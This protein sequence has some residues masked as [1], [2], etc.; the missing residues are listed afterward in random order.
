MVSDTIDVSSTTTTSN[1]SR[2]SRLCRNRV[3]PPGSQPSNRCR[4]DAVSDGSRA[5]PTG[6]AS[7]PRSATA[8]CSRAAAL[9]VG[10]ASATRSGGP[11]WSTQ[12]R[13]HPGHRGGLPGP[14]PAAEH[15]RPPGGG[16]LAPPLLSRRP[17]PGRAAAIRRSARRGRP[18][19]AA[20]RPGRA[21]PRRACSSCRRYRSRY[22][23]PYSQRNGLPRADQRAGQ[24]GRLP[25]IGL[26]PRQ[27]RVD[28]RQRVAPGP[29]R[30][31]PNRCARRARRRRSPAGP[32][33]RPRPPAPPAALATCTS[34]AEARRPG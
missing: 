12:Q 11:G 32:F 6:R 26:R 17:H 8:S 30:C 7:A 2:L 34:A 24:H 18:P 3:P 10:A 25:G 27:R 22:S 13:E 20:G 14:R 31:R 15:G 9:P 1:G 23:S 5:G 33:R 16:D 21:D 28:L 19:A 29:G 4:V